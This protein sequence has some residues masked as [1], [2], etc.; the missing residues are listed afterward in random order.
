MLQQKKCRASFP[1]CLR[2]QGARGDISSL[3]LSLNAPQ[4]VGLAH[5]CSCLRT[6]LLLP[7]PLPPGSGLFCCPGKVQGLLSLVLHLVRG[8]DSSPALMTPGSGISPITG[9]ELGGQFLSLFHSATTG[10]QWWAQVFSSVES[11]RDG[12]PATPEMGG[13]V[14]SMAAG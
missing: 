1:T 10:N 5:P 3:H 11:S 9:G 4:M 6:D 14:Q 13:E 12:F 8:M 7:L 2:W